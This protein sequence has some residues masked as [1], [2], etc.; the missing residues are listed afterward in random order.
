ML[1]RNTLRNL[2]RAAARSAPVRTRLAPAL[3]TK[4]GA[5]RFA[6]SVM[7][8]QGA[9]SRALSA[10]APGDSVASSLAH[11][12]EREKDLELEEE[13]KAGGA[14]SAELKDLLDMV[15]E[16]MTVES[17]EGSNVVKLKM[18]HVNQAGEA[19]AVE[20]T[21]NVQ[22]YQAAEDAMLQED[23][24]D[25]MEAQNVYPFEV[26]VTK[27]DKALRFFCQAGAAAMVVENILVAPAGV[28]DDVASLVSMSDKYQG[29]NFDDLEADL[30]SAFI[31]YLAE[32]YVDDTLAIFI[33]AYA[34]YKEQQ[35]YL[36]WLSDVHAFIK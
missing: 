15:Q 25:P 22:E 10:Q 30:Q 11:M 35:L 32:R 26:V 14:M 27:R 21:F 4:G 20:V 5:L 2:A 8:R 3:R 17:T 33:E 9:P 23:E 24:A 36:E 16:K 31:E 7:L 34:D 28:G 1:L 12:L 29:P 13:Q 18:D 19:E 6:P